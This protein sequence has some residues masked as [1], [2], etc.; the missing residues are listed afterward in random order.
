MKRVFVIL[1]AV[2][3]VTTSIFA[4]NSNAQ[5]LVGV[6]VDPDIARNIYYLNI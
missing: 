1:V 4:Q 3:A 5:L 6:P 2:M